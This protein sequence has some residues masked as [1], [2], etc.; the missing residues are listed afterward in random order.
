MAKND[1][2]RRAGKGAA[3][4]S[5][6]SSNITASENSRRT[7]FTQAARKAANARLLASVHELRAAKRATALTAW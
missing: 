5:V 1:G 6:G 4:S 2:S 3:G 7:A